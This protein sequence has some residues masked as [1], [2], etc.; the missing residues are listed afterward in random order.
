[1]KHLDI[2]TKDDMRSLAI[3]VN[4][5]NCAKQSL[6]P[7]AVPVYAPV[8]ARNKYFREAIFALADAQY[9]EDNF[10]RNLA[11]QYGIEPKDREKM[12]LDF[13]TNK[14]FLRD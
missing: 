13:N 11:E 8:N 14:L 7:D 10:W 2:L 5:I 9:L 3:T 4:K 6:R 1:M 12:Y